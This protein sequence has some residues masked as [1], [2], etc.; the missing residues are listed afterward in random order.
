M[1]VLGAS[2]AAIKAAEAKPAPPARSLPVSAMRTVAA[3]KAIAPPPTKTTPPSPLSRPSS[4]GRAERAFGPR[5]HPSPTQ[6][7]V[8][9]QKT[10]V[11]GSPGM[12]SKGDIRPALD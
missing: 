2:P 6:L 8:P 9:T 3:E 1:P 10:P 5:P 7:R 12:V 11:P 4:R